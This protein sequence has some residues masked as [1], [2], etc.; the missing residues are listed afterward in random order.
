MLISG[1]E[2]DFVY[3][4]SHTIRKKISSLSG[5]WNHPFYLEIVKIFSGSDAHSRELL[6]NRGCFHSIGCGGPQQRDNK[7][8]VLNAH[9]QVHEIMVYF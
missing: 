9:S 1:G 3:G 4:I 6:S 2:T 7:R 5:K 8:M